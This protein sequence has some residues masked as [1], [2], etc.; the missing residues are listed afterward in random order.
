MTF[1]LQVDG[2][3]WR[4]N[5]DA[6]L[7]QRDDPATG[8]RVV[9][10]A[11]SN[12]YGLGQ[13]LLAREMRARHRTVLSVGTVYEAIEQ[14]LEW[15]GELLVLTPWNVA[16]QAAERAWRQARHD[17]GTRLITT[18]GDSASLR[19]LAKAAR[20]ERPTRVLIEALTS[21]QRF[22]F[23]EPE[24]HAALR[25]PAV[26]AAVGTGALRF[27]GSALH[28]PI[29]TPDVRSAAARHL[30][31]TTTGPVVA[32]SAKVVQAV[33]WGQVWLARMA[34]MQA[35]A[36]AAADFSSA[37]DIWVSHLS[38]QELQQ[39]RE[40]LPGTPVHPRIG[41]AL[42]LGDVDSLQ[43]GGVVLA[44]H[45]ST[46]GGAG[47]FQ[48]HVPS[49][50]HLV[51]VGG[52]TNHGVG[53]TA[54][55][56]AATLRRRV[57]TAGNGLLDAAGRP[58]SAFRWQGKRLWLHEAPHA[59]VS[60]VLVGKGVRP[61]NVGDILPAQIRLSIAHFDEVVGLS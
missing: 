59:S 10:V 39:L 12:G 47:Y 7:A 5:I 4:A 45:P 36:G 32:G 53:L 61:P 15:D 28:L 11:K 24:I 30:G 18:V 58:M 9:P 33:E 1:V 56:G 23:I 34:E 40:A 54:P 43:P 38:A 29:A 35:G 46:P 49:G 2:Q 20:P 31:P 60:L 41:T 42:W 25:D 16:D 8:G 21:V 44:V 22:G 26:V 57:T 3:G 52:G 17:Y 37:A 48:R 55:V 6:V 51:V 50:A 14:H 19:A 13:A 27:A